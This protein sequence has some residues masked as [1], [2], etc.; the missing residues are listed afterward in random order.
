MIRDSSFRCLSPVF[1][2]GVDAQKLDF[3]D[4]YELS[5]KTRPV[6][7]LQ[8]G[9]ANSLPDAVRLDARVPIC[10]RMTAAARLRLV[11]TLLR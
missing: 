5:R 11:R 1:L 9:R 4:D 8:C 7:Y 3:H 2:F 10:L 6:A